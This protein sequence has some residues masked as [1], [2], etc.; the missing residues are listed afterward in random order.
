MGEGEGQGEVTQEPVVELLEGLEVR[1]LSYHERVKA[2]KE[3]TVK[4]YST[5]RRGRCIIQ[6]VTR[7]EET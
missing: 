3:P 2:P 7:E 1:V 4:A 5:Q 6:I